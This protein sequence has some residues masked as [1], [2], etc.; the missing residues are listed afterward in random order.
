[1]EELRSTDALDREIL[2]DAR[3]KAEKTLKSAEDAAREAE[4]AW[5]RK[6]S[7]DL[8]ALEG[9]HAERI[10]RRRAETFARLPLD[11]RRIRVERAERFLKES[12]DSFLRSLPRERLLAA[13]EREL[14]SRAAEL[15]P[16]PARVRARGLKVHE[17]ESVL[18]RAL[19]PVRWTLE[20]PG[21]D[22]EALPAIL[23]EAGSVTVRCGIEE[24]GEDLLRDRRGELAVALLGP[25]A[26]D[27]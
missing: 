11:Q 17:A 12:M 9:K 15:A 23:A 21:A 18:S 5:E 25:E 19:G 22:P 2:E 14:S 20:A 8:R 4:A 1:M 26:A 13:L 27:D 3:R 6:L 10:T 24:L 16:G 7:E